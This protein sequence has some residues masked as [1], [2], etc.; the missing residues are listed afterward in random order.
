M[1]GR[2]LLA[3]TALL[4][5][6]ASSAQAAASRTCTADDL[7]G[8][9]APA[10][11]R[12]HGLDTQD[13]PL[14]A[15]TRYRVVAVPERA[16]GDR[17][18]AVDGSITVTAPNGPP[19]EPLTENG[20]PAWDFTP[21]KGGSIQFVVAWEEEIGSPGSGDVCAASQTFD[22]PVLAP[23]AP[24]IKG[25]F[26]RG[27]NVFGS[28][29]ALKLTGREPQDPAPIKVVLRAR[30]NTT[31]PPAPTGKA[32][33]TLTFTPDGDGTF[34]SR[35]VSRKLSR[36]FQ[37]DSTGNGLKIF[38]YPNIAFGT[39]LRFAFS[40]EV[41]Q[42]GGRIGGMRSGASCRRIQFRQRS[43]IKCRAVGLQQ[44]P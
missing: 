38:P 34:T 35:S 33:A 27:D 17:G 5:I 8:V 43:A 11:L 36:T 20:R 39:T 23:T 14:I 1:H 25:T 22:L 29:F 7:Q 15:G 13:G 6:P 9:K 40:I 41:L 30:K 3:A 31:T 28:S 19:L 21:P 12:D 44:R 32:L 26:S 24:R 42:G 4:L 18:Q 10:M 16:N 2:L 37:A